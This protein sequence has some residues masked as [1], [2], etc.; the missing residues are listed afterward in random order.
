MLFLNKILRGASDTLPGVKV[1]LVVLIVL[2]QTL[3]ELESALFVMVILLFPVF[4]PD[5]C[6]KF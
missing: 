6:P 5:F 4:L 1:F 2:Q 3:I